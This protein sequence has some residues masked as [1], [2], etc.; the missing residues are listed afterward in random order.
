MGVRRTIRRLARLGPAVLVLAA[1]ALAPAAAP[2]LAADLVLSR[3]TTTVR[4][5][6]AITFTGHGDPAISRRAGSRSSSTSRAPRGRSSPTSCHRGRPGRV[7]LRYVLATPSGGLYPNT[8]VTAHFRA[9][10]DDGTEVDGPSVTIRYDDTRYDWQ[11]LSGDLVTVHWT[12]GGTAF[13]RRALRIAEDA[14]RDVGDLLGVTESDPIDFIVYADRDAFYDVLG[15][16]SRENVGGVAPLGVRTLFALIGPAA[17]DAP[18]VSIVIPHELTHLVFDTAVA[19]PVPL[20][21]PL[22]ERGD[23]RLPRRGLHGAATGRTSRRR[24]RTGR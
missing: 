23:R 18:W 5:L 3:P 13:G 8:Q 2:V 21:A 16:A 11:V 15:A 6:E 4:F 14:V 22:A 9:T 24:R 7:E 20:P 12:E 1:A 10:L 17:I 19:Q